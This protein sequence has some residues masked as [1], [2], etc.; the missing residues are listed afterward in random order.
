M[1]SI[2]LLPLSL[3]LTLH[4]VRYCHHFHHQFH[5][6]YRLFQF[7]CY[8][9][10]SI[11]TDQCILAL[12][13]NIDTYLR[14][15]I[16]VIRTQSFQALIRGQACFPSIEFLKDH[17]LETTHDLMEKLCQDWQVKLVSI[18]RT[19]NCNVIEIHRALG[20]VAVDPEAE[21]FVPC[22]INILYYFSIGIPK[23][24]TFFNV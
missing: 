9:F 24:T 17:L 20:L 12:K 3:H 15:L 18:H 11:C 6:R 8:N 16:F 10:H 13:L 5:F 19:G 22:V 7:H 1:S 23:N 4:S 21:F 14:K 2:N